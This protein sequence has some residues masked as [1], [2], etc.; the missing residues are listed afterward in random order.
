MDTHKGTSVG[1]RNSIDD[2][3]PDVEVLASATDPVFATLVTFAS[4]CVHVV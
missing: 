3:T 1:R 4:T 2:R